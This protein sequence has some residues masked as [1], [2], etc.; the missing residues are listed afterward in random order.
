MVGD[1][2]QWEPIFLLQGFGEEDPVEQV[3]PDRAEWIFGILI[4][5]EY[6]L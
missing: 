5:L 1:W 6:P 3:Y 4:S 2:L